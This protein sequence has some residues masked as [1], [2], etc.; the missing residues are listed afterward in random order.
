M[1][2]FLDL[3]EMNGRY[4]TELGHAANRVIQ[5]G[6]YIQGE[7]CRQFEEEFAQYCGVR[8]AVGVASGLDALSLIF[9]AFKEIGKLKDGDEVIV[10]ANTYIAS[11][12]AISENKLVPVLVEPEYDS[13]NLDPQ[14]LKKA[15]SSRTKAILAVHLYGR[16]AD[17]VSINKIAST[18]KLLVIEDAAQSHG[19]KVGSRK[20]GSFGHAAGFSFYP[21]KNLGALGDAGA[22]TTNDSELS[23]AIR[24]LGNYGSVTKYENIYRGLNS[25]LDEMQAA[26]LR[27]KLNFLES[28]TQR[29]REIAGMYIDGITSKD[30]TLPLSRRC[31]DIESF[32]AHVWHLFV[33]RSPIRDRL[34]KFLE[35]KGVQTLVHY[36]IAIH[37]Q[38]AYQEW[39]SLNLPISEAMSEE[40]LSL[41]ISPIMSDED[42]FKT[43]DAVNSFNEAS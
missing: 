18:H 21:G 20:A 7:E 26:F 25:R 40:V 10:P 2:K 1:I 29:R 42:V 43:I 30:I 15:L 35:S 34:K 13:Y 32:E 24:A 8:F 6:W 9:R 11:V 33:V 17:M 38:L 39:S 4:I 37:H 3:K 28:D 16:L 31:F 14:K 22:V 19:A 12:F 36:P 27:V 23:E 41:P 5:S